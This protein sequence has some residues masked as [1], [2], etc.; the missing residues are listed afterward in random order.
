MKDHV[1]MHL[2]AIELSVPQMRKFLHHFVQMAALIFHVPGAII[3]F[4]G[5]DMVHYK[6]GIGIGG[7]KNANVWKHLHRNRRKQKRHLHY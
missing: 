2:P 6:A 4:V 5:E 7:I 3:A 1:S